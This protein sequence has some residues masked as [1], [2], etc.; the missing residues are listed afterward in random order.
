MSVAVSTARP[1]AAPRRTST[2]RQ[3]R[4]FM[5]WCLAPALAVLMIVTLAPTIYLIVTSF[6]PL[7]LT[8]PATAWNFSHPLVNY[9]L[10]LGD[11]RFHNSLWVQAKLS[12][13]TVQ[14][15][16]ADRH[17]FALLLNL[18]SRH[19]QSAAHRLPDPDGTAA[20]RRRDHLEGA[21]HA[22]HQPA[23]TMPRPCGLDHAVAHHRSPTGRCRPSSSPIPGS[24]F[25]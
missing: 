19:D 17:G 25:R 13:W 5:V 14:P 1:I 16:D 24:G 9:R 2:A 22:R 21:L 15:A 11:E 8:N 10:L 20:D 12:F 4:W 18:Q 7:N 6:T 3:W 23:A